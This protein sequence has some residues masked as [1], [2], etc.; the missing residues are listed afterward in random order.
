MNKV[1]QGYADLLPIGSAVK[2][3]PVQG[4]PECRECEIRSE[5]WRLGHGAIVI[6]VTGRAGGVSVDHLMKVTAPTQGVR[7]E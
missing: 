3:F 4:E 2:Y 1:L 6:K 5:P 7:S